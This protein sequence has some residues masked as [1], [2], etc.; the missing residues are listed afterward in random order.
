MLCYLEKGKLIWFTTL[1][2]DGSGFG[3]YK[4]IV[5]VKELEAPRGSAL[6]YSS[7]ML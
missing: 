4:N 6:D 2:I 1:M 5:I 7:M 3:H